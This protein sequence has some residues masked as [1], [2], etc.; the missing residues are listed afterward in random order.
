MSWWG[1]YVDGKVGPVYINT[2]FVYDTGKVAT[3]GDAIV[4]THAISCRRRQKS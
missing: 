3:H 4:D 2:D 1:L